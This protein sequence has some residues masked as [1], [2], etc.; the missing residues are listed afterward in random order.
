M[1]RPARAQL[2][3]EALRIARLAHLRI[4]LEVKRAGLRVV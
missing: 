1:L 3:S 2:K 4:L